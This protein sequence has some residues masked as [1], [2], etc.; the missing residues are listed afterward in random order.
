MRE[1]VSPPTRISAILLSAGESTRM[2]R[3]KALLPWRGTTLLQYQ[4]R[5]LL[6][7]G[8]EEIVVVLGYR[9][10]SLRPLLVGMPGVQPVLNLRCRTGKSSSVR[11]GLRHIAPQAEGILVLAVDQPRTPD[12]MRSVIAV[13]QRRRPLVAYPAYQGRGGHPVI[14]AREL[15]PEMMRIRESRQ[16]LREVVERHR[17][18][19]SR[20]EMDDPQV[21]LDLNDPE[22]YERAAKEAGS[23]G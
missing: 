6:A 4:V 2:G 21:L 9:A 15:L 19:A 22:E 3:Q 16:G 5:S 17:P 14:F 12:L 8:I 18:Q 11:A 7:A 1:N 20:I 10:E 13:Y 23:A